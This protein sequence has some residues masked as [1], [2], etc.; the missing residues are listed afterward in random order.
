M[1][2]IAVT[3]GSGGAGG[4]TIR[5]LV[6]H[7][8]EVV[9]VDHAAPTETL[10]P[11]VETDM[12]DFT[13]VVRAFDGCDAVAHFAGNPHPDNDFASGADRFSGNTVSCFNAFQAAAEV[14]IKRVAWASSETVY[15]FPFATN[16]PSHMPLSEADRIDPQTAYAISKAASEF[17]AI[18][19][20][21][22]HGIDFLGLR[23]SNV[24]FTD[25]DHHA[26]YSL[27]PSYWP[28][29]HSRKFNLWGYIDSRDTGRATRLALESDVRG[30]EVFN[31]AAKDTIM[32]QD[33]RQLLEAVFPNTRVLPGTWARQGFL[34]GSKAK[35][36]FGFEPEHNW[37]E[38]LGVG[39]GADR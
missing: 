6:A 26:S 7:G 37:S 2:K 5:E 22:L 35:A 24:L 20:H 36:M 4:A 32:K 25:P 21:R 9:N 29:F 33:N 38:V 12:M 3:G 28:D 31:I 16:V 27:I 14:G 10:C 1:K 19:M 18:E 17:V 11:Y 39:A 34:D 8:Y 30:A 15:G 23:L 13:A